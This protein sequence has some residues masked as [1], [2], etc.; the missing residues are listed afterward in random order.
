MN[1]FEY[2]GV[3]S[4]DMGLRIQSKNVFSAPEYEVDFLSIPGR[5]GD[6]I[7]GGGRFPNVQ[8]TYSVFLPAKTLSE[9][10]RKITAVKSWLYAGLEQYHTLSDSYDTAFFRQG[11]YAGK[12]DIED[13]LNRIGVNV[14][15]VARARNQRMSGMSMYDAV[16]EEMRTKDE[17]EAFR[18]FRDSVDKLRAEVEGLRLD[19]QAY[20]ETGGDV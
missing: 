6:L 7:S 11:V 15:Q 17:A 8:V 2:N 12:L 14:N 18:E 13:E 16:R 3:S 4:L 19:L 5:D 10:S 9:L 20:A 1:Y